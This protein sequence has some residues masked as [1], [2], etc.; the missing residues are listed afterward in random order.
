MPVLIVGADTPVGA[1]I[2]N[3]LTDRE[4]ELRCFV[5]DPDAAADLKRLSAKI[6]L[7]DVSDGSHVGAAGLNCFSMVFVCSAATDNRER[8]FGMTPAQVFEQWQEAITMAGARRIIWVEDAD[9]IGSGSRITAN[10]IAV[11]AG[12]DLSADDIADRVVA[13]D[14]VSDLRTV[15]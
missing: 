2:V 13:L 9:T 7:G 5:T 11:V 1:T 3:A 10:E 14:E 12:A 4:G 15:L 6:A 8:A